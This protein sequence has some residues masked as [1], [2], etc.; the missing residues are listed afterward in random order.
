MEQDLMARAACTIVSLNYLAYARTLCE[1]FL[2]FHP[3][4][5]FYVL[6]V[7][8]LPADFVRE[9]ELF[10]MVLVEEL[11]I[12]D[13][14]SVAFKYDILELNTNVKPTFLKRLLGEGYEQVLYLD[15][16]ICV[17][18]ELDTVYE[19]LRAHSIVLTPHVLH[20]VADGGQTE[21]IFL[22]GGSFNLGFIAIGAGE[23][24][25]R[26][27]D[28]WEER[29]L[30][31]A[32]DE[33]RTGLFVDQK[34]LNLATCFFPSVGVLRDPASN[35]AYWNLQ[36][37]SLSAGGDGWIVN[38]S[39]PLR[40]YHFSGIS[41]DGGEQISK[42][43]SINLAS[44]PDLRDL[45]M[46]Y[47]ERLV[48][49]GIRHAYKG[50]YAFGTFE[51]GQY[52]N[53]LTRAI[54]ASRLSEFSGEDPFR[55][56]SK[57]YKWAEGA[58]VLGSSDTMNAHTAKNFEGKDRRIRAIHFVLRLLLRVVGADRYTLLLKYLSYISILRNQADVLIT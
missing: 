20:P 50:G 1:S 54:Y 10:E 48:R 43:V 12:A 23:E 32:F 37:R 2:H 49:H 47:R 35:M 4:C 34:W 3:D 17:Y 44:R 56:T 52:I 40:F 53:R 9:E 36:E 26:F 46:D 42:F 55:A 57:F 45:F 58:H 33:Q 28:W 39:T 22:S 13:F 21:R 7:D 14:T 8:R 19:A 27:L 15:P 41:V 6:V 25:N 24:T 30:G 38:Q 5:R 31:L 16:D 11:G 51:N 18:H 29:C